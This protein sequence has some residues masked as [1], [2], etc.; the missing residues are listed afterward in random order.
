MDGIVRVAVAGMGWWGRHLA[1]KLDQSSGPL[2][3]ATTVDPDPG[4]GADQTDLDVV[5][6]DPAVD[7]VALCV[8][9]S[10]HL[11]LILRCVEAGK[12]PF[13]EKPLALD[14]TDARRAVDA[15][16][17]AGLV[18]GIGHERRFEDAW[19]SVARAVTDGSLGVVLHADA[20]MSH[21]RFREVPADHWR[22][23][24]EEAPA[25]GMTAM[26]VHLT[27]VLIAMFGRVV[28]VSARTERRVLPLPTGDVVV[29]RLGFS[30]GVVGTISVI[31]ATP[32]Y[33]RLAI[34]GSEGWIEVRD[35]AHPEE[36]SGAMVTRCSRG[37][38][39]VTEH[40]AGRTDAVLAN[41]EAFALAVLGLD[42][43]PVSSSDMVHN[44]EV[45]EAI[46]ASAAEGTVRRLASS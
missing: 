43:Y 12:H 29:A 31:S 14:R 39:P 33:G 6:A 36:N 28:E 35:D 26:G 10:A 27:D 38:R 11:A 34:F 32:F 30:S 5:L 40:V 46:A 18:L 2:R 37:G 23:S 16:R 17:E 4:V 25:A 45:L 22:G 44:V 1:G 24:I 15:C 20:T 41:L 13:C 8:P 42:D 19:R 3:L 21:D 9:H 7:A